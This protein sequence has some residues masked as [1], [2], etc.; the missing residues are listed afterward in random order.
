MIRAWL[1]TFAAYLIAF[2]EDPIVD[3]GG[4]DD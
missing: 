3:L 2:T 4:D 1:W